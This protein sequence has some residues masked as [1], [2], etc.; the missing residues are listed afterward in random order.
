MTQAANLA[1]LGTNAGTTGILPAAGGG[2]GSTAGVTGFKNRIINGDMRIAQRGTGSFAVDNGN[3]YYPADRFSAYQSVTGSK[4]SIQQNAG[5]VTPP[6]GF[7]YYIGATVTSAYSP[8]GTDWFPIRQTIEGYNVADL[9]FGT[10]N[11]KTFTASFWVRSSLTGTMGGA[12]WNN[13]GSRS[14]PFTYTIS[15]A[16][17]WEYKT[18]TVPGCTDGTWQT[19]NLGGL[20]ISW[21]MGAGSTYTGTAGA[22]AN[23]YYTSAT[24]ATNIVATSG[25][26]LYIAG[27]QIE[28]G[29]AATDFDV[30]DYGSEFTRC[31]RYFQTLTETDIVG[32]NGNWAAFGWGSSWGGTTG[33]SIFY[34]PPLRAAPSVAFTAPST[35]ARHAPGINA[36]QCNGISAQVPNA[37][38]SVI[39][40]TGPASFPSGAGCILTA[41][42]SATA[43]ISSNAEL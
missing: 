42:A 3:W 37:N 22:W 10:A 40:G 25:A 26:T 7:N 34:N 31:Q 1:A 11:A 18:I 9:L 17:T 28:V 6:T 27:V 13:D 33:I 21:S 15:S 30:R 19:T 32:S 29:S 43:T 39:L 20:T 38:T 24:G 23:T 4:F 5:S 41:A 14:Y 8:T 16:N 35:F 2:T 36:E 12:F